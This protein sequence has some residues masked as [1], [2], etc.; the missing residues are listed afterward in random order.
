MLYS[1][2]Q[3]PVLFSECPDDAVAAQISSG[4]I[5]LGL[6]SPLPHP[7]PLTPTLPPMP[8]CIFLSIVD[9]SMCATCA[10]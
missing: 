10:L 9:G 1:K 8:L 3:L 7:P 4:L 6:P 2:K 5:V